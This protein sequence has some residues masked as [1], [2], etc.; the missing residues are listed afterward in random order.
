MQ[1]FLHFGSADFL[2]GFFFRLYIILL[3]N[4][5]NY[6]RNITKIVDV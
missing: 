6:A 2:L 5:Y 4:S 3:G 1:V